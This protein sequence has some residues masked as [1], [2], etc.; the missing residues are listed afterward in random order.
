MKLHLGCGERK[1]KG[2]IGLDQVNHSCVDR[3]CDLNVGIPYPDNSV[4]N[5]EAIH[6]LEHLKDPV[7]IMNEIWRVCKHGAKVHI[8][9]PSAEG[10]GAF[11]D[12]T[13]L[14]GSFWV[15]NSFFYY[16]KCMD[17]AGC[18]EMY[19]KWYK[20]S[21]AWT[22]FK[23]FFIIRKIRNKKANYGVVNVEVQMD[24]HKGQ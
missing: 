20:S 14:K 9:V 18:P 2:Y 21:P 12:P 19:G 13:H 5:I 8:I 1:L 10:P 16:G 22:G 24:A 4:T 23:G 3:V 11:Q 15:R 7:H 6:V 17:K